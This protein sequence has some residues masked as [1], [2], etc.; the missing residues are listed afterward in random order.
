MGGGIFH[1]KVWLKLMLML[2]STPQLAKGLP[3]P[4]FGRQE[5]ALQ[6]LKVKLLILHVMCSW[7]RHMQSRMDFSYASKQAVAGY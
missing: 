5:E 1:L 6:L 4:L 3:L 2:L 7:L